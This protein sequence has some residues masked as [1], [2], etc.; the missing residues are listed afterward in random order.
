MLVLSDKLKDVAQLR[1]ERI[2]VRA[3][4]HFGTNRVGIWRDHPLKGHSALSIRYSKEDSA[5]ETLLA[6]EA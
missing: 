5:I 1:A 2:I 6:I 4:V 3:G